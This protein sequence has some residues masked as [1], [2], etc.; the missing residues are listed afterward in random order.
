[1]GLFSGAL[2]LAVLVVTTS[3]DTPNHY[4]GFTIGACVLAATKV[5]EGIDQVAL[6]PAIATG[7]NMMNYFNGRS[8]RNPSII[9]W[10]TYLFAPFAGASV[11]AAI[12]WRTRLREFRSSKKLDQSE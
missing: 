6:N 5:V 7:M 8:A 1:M 12:F 10:M 9:A 2:T 4:Y 3:E 11:A